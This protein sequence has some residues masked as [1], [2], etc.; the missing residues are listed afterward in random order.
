MENKNKQESSKSGYMD[1]TDQEVDRM[2]EEWDIVK[3][4]LCHKK[5]SMLKAKLILIP[6][7]GEVFVCR[8]H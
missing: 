2:L 3:C 6:G 7:K 5:I 8:N 1:I 4:A